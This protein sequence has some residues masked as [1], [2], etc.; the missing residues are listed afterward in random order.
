M[1]DEDWGPY[2]CHTDQRKPPE[3]EV[4]LMAPTVSTLAAGDRPQPLLWRHPSKMTA[5][6]FLMVTKRL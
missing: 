5:M 6:L 4:G 3:L 1:P 2:C